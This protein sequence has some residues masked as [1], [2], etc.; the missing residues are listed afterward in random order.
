MTDNQPDDITGNAP[1]NA[2]DITGVSPSVGVALRE[3]RMRLGLG[4]ADVA[5]HI[6]FAPRQIE[7]LEQND[8]ASL[9]ETAFVRG[10]VRSY[11]RLLQL[12]PAPLLAALPGVSAQPAPSAPVTLAE[13]PFPTIYAARKPNIIWLSAALAVAAALALFTWL[14]GNAPDAPKEQPAA[15]PAI[16]AVLPASAAPDAEVMKAPQA[17]PPIMQPGATPPAKP[18]AASGAPHQSAA[19]HLVFDEESWAHVTGKDGNVLLSQLNPG[20]SK[21]DINGTPPFAV[22]IGRASGV[23]LYYK[24]QAVNLKPHTKA[25]VSHLTL[26]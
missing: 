10:F 21:Q 12:D 2:Q 8:F 25:E 18:V 11:A 5:S 6:K 22:V 3:A 1:N 14:H 20:G 4:V 7:A 17:A 19:I 13:V 26:E 16:P 15:A 9:P 23:R 24:G